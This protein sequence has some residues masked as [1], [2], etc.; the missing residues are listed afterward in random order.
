MIIWLLQVH[1]HLLSGQRDQ[2]LSG[3]GSQPSYI[4]R[5]WPMADCYFHPWVYTLHVATWP[6]PLHCTQPWCRRIQSTFSSSHGY[7][8]T[9]WYQWC[10]KG[11]KR[12]SICLKIYI[13]ENGI[14]QHLQVNFEQEPWSYN[15]QRGERERRIQ[16]ECHYVLRSRRAPPCIF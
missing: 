16:N 13:G 1:A 12:L 8:C 10:I 9:V 7:P 3:M 6:H 5:F 14:M 2:L 11:R 4:S 15:L